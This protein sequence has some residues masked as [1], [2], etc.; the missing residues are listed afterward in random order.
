MHR[1]RYLVGLL[2]LVAAVIGLLFLLETLGGGDAQP[3]MALRVEWR[4]ARGLRA[5]ADVR[6][7]G[8]TVGTVRAVQVGGDG[9]KAQVDLV[10]D[11]AGSDQACVDSAFWIVSPRFTGIASGASGLD[12]LV[13][14]AYVAFVTPDQRGSQLNSGSL[15]VGRERPPQ[16]LEPETLEPV[17]H[18][19]L[20]MT[21]LVPE[22]HGLHPGATVIFRGVT[23]GDVRSVELA[24]DG[25][26][27]EVALRIQR[28]YRHTVTDR[29]VFWIARPYVSGALFSGFT[30][31][32]VSALL[33]PYVAYHTTIGTGAPAEDG[34][35]AVAAAVRPDLRIDDVP[36]KALA[37]RPARP[38]PPADPLVLVRVSYSAV[39]ED[40]FSPDDKILRTGT[41]VLYLDSS[42]RPVVLTA[43][44]L[45]DASY[46]ERDLFGTDP[47]ITQEQIKVMLPGGSV[48]RA[49]RVWVDGSGL[50]LALLI[51]EGAPPDLTGTPADMLRFDPTGTAPVV[52]DFLRQAG[53]DARPAPAMPLAAEA[54]LPGVTEH[55]GA[56]LLHAGRVAGILGQRSGRDI[57]PA[58]QPIASVPADLRPG[59]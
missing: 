57:K 37:Q 56:A 52:L 6:Y 12:T 14:D 47:D 2:T 40:W 59:S 58:A 13:R 41:G 22:N 8:V 46:T 54:G 42:G 49:G 55:R 51:L 17:G 50:D 44:S 27:V 7:R 26:H 29:S 35:R 30:V 23:T 48:L 33:S 31:A 15:V 11:R 16:A 19:D 43:R 53:D 3:G 36:A 4:D 25:S 10:L 1:A 24:A 28:R 5:G 20:L 9:G 34:F 32:D 45:V 18:G 39:E 21:L 38:T